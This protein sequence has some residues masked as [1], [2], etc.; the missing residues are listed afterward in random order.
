MKKCSLLWLDL[1]MTGLDA[2]KDVILEIAV[3]ATDFNL[4]TLIEGPDLVIHQPET[5]LQNMNKWVQK[6]HSASGLLERVA[7][8]NIAVQ[9][10]E[11]QVLE[12]VHD[13][14]EQ[15]FHFAGNS[16]YQDRSFL[17]K[18]MPKLNNKA[19]YRLIDVSTIKVLVKA[20]YPNSPENLFKK[21]KT[22]RAFD[23]VRE[24]ITEL[25][26]FRNYFFK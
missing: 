7:S 8:S 25:R 12:F 18:Y 10:A 9:E 22:H 24:S 14:C 11:K 2:E 13:S 3:A 4:E 21:N 17:K 16:I 1:E 20:W 15:D 23:D 5:A 19:H 6:T 26:H